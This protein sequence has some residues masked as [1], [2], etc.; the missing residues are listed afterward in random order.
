MENS[1][2]I[3]LGGRNGIKQDG[4]PIPVGRSP[5]RV[6]IGDLNGDGKADLVVANERDNNVWVLLSK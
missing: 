6:A 1:V 5:Q 3:Y 4:S 2:T